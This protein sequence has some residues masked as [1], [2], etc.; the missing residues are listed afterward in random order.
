MLGIRTVL[1]CAAL[2][3]L[4]LAQTPLFQLLDEPISRGALPE[5]VGDLD[6]DGDADLVTQSGVF[7]NDGHGRFTA[8]PGAPLAF[9]KV[10]TTLADVNNDGKLDVVWI[11]SA[12]GSGSRSTSAR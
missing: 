3:A 6:G 1:A 9:A 5:A 11:D 12:T 10:R 2:A 8:V 7:A 4:G